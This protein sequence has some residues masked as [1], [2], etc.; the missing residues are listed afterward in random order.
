MLSLS[1]VDLVRAFSLSLALFCVSSTAGG[2]GV[3]QPDRQGQVSPPAPAKGQASENAPT[4]AGDQA[5]AKDA[6]SIPQSAPVLK[7]RVI[8]LDPGHG[9][10]DPGAMYNGIVEKDLTL[11]VSLSLRTKLVAL[12]AKV[13]MTRDVDSTLTLQERLDQSNNS[14]PDLFLSIHANA[15]GNRAISGIETYW[16]DSADQALSD[17][18]LSTLSV[19]LNDPAKWSMQRNLFVLTG[20]RAP[21]SLVE[22][23]YLTNKAR[24]ALL[25]TSTYQDKV[26][27]SLSRALVAYLTDPT[28]LKGCQPVA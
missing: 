25:K 16:H 13:E 1:F 5:H 9:G 18:F 12:G 15:V 19:D 10:N 17:L 27:S 24:A 22:I 14:C 4:Q 28:T 23:G 7:G 26:A 8:L 20:N 2:A 11:A 3:V 6:D 21:A